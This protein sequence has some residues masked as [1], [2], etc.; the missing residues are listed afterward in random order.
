MKLSKE[1]KILLLKSVRSAI[2]GLFSKVENVN[3]DVIAH[4]VFAD[5]AG[6]FVTITKNGILRGCIGYIISDNPLFETIQKAAVQ[7]AT[8]DPRFPPLNFDEVKNIELEISILSEPFL[9][10]SYDDVIVGQHGLI[11]EEGI[12]RG[13]LLPQVPVE[14]NMNRDE[15]LS[16]LCQKAGLYQNY[17]RENKV[18]L[19]AFTA[20]VFSEQSLENEE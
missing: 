18:K 2:N 3:L 20:T 17:W 5:K 4:P 9:L 8:S 6:V 7:A 1:E 16:A 19:K 15:Y 11:L 10:Q 14:H 12:Y 13:L